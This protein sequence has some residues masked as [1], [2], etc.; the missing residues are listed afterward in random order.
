[1]KKTDKICCLNCDVVL[2][3][4]EEPGLESGD[5]RKKKVSTAQ[6]YWMAATVGI[7]RTVACVEECTALQ[8]WAELLN[9]T[10]A[11][12]SKM[13]TADSSAG[14]TGTAQRTVT[15][16]ASLSLLED[17]RLTPEQ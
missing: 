4:V 5:C 1:M 8:I 9:G 14:C 11:I 16:T 10:V 15:A 17:L 12:V 3:T 7:C 6:E 13:C 2:R